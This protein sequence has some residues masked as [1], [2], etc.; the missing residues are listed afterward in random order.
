M[1]DVTAE[2]RIAAIKAAVVLRFDLPD[3]SMM[4]HRR[5]RCEARPRQIAMYL[6]RELTP[7]SL[8]AI[9]KQFARDHTT[10]MH[11]IK[12]VERLFQ[13][14]AEMRRVVTELREEL[15]IFGQEQTDEC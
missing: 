6:A 14:S 10:V 2:L 13:E 4:N 7:L 1:P 5:C 3:H 8:P 11:A 12:T 9:G 15:T